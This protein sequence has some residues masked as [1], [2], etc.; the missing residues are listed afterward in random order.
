[1]WILDSRVQDTALTCPPM[2]ENLC[3]INGQVYVSFESAASFYR[4]PEDDKGPSKDPVD[5]VYKLDPSRF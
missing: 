4:L 2:T 3:S 1:M 5:R